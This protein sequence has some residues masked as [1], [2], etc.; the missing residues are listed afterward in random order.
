MDEEKGDL[1]RRVCYVLIFSFHETPFALAIHLREFLANFGNNDDFISI[2][3]SR[4]ISLLRAGSGRA[5]SCCNTRGR[6]MG[7]G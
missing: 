2:S 7:T 1:D 5:S 3:G 4:S 6:R